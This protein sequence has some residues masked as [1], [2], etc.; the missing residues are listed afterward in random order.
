M[1][2][3]YRVNSHVRKILVIRGESRPDRITVVLIK[4]PVGA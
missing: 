3:I 4:E 2:K 1:Q